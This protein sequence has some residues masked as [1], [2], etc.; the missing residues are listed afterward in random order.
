MESY[1]WLCFE[2][3]RDLR[4][5]FI[6]TRANIRANS[7]WDALFWISFIYQHELAYGPYGG[8][9]A[10]ST[11]EIAQH[12]KSLDLPNKETGLPDRT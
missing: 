2:P 5:R 4:A 9:I 1:N 12:V 7:I 8:Y 3:E 11:M 10:R 6:Q